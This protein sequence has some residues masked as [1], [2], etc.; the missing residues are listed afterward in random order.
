MESCLLNSKKRGTN[1]RDDIYINIVLTNSMNFQML[2]S[3][4]KTSKTKVAIQKSVLTFTLL[5]INMKS[6]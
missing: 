3:R 4:R 1:I 6:D 2:I 5:I